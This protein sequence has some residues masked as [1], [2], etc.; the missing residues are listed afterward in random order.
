MKNRKKAVK[1]K[2]K[3]SLSKIKLTK[4]KR[5]LTKLMTMN[6]RLAQDLVRNLEVIADHIQDPNREV[7][8]G[9]DLDRHREAVAVV[10]AVPC[11]KRQTNHVDQH[12]GQNL[13]RR[14]VEV[15]P[16]HHDLVQDHERQIDHVHQ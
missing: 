8:P 4:M 7:D 12:L 13:I 15:R 3:R 6:V 9:Q 1:K 5:Y 14:A 2:V 10:A 11:H 16:D